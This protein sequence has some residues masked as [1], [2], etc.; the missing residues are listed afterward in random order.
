MTSPSHGMKSIGKNDLL[1]Y[2]N[3]IELSGI[4]EGHKKEVTRS[5]ENYLNFINWKIDK[6]KSLTYFKKLQKRC[7]IA[8]Y[9]KQMYQIKKFLKYLGEEWIK[10]I[11]L[12][13]DPDYTP[14][15]VTSKDISDTISY[16]QNDIHYNRYKSIILLG[17]TSGLRAEELYKLTPHDLDMENRIVYIRHDPKSNH[18]TKTGKNRVSFFTN[19]TKDVLLCYLNEH[20]NGK[21]LFPQKTIERA[22]KDSPLRVKD[23]RKAFSQDWT[24]KHG[25]TGVK[26]ILM[27]HSLKNDVDLMHYNAQSEE[28]LKQI[29]DKVMGSNM[30]DIWAYSKVE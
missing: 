14:K 19:Q 4:T 6:Q 3:I 5:L 12:P 10:D 25:D 11:K 8:Y 22:F 27:G 20:D 7:S 1:E 23:L 26:K 18:S 30:L 13:A 28:D 24:R 2:I 16:F 29:Y 15:R 21:T 9:K 17:Y